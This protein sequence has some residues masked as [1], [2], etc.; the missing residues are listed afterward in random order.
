MKQQQQQQQH[1]RNREKKIWKILRIHTLSS[2]L[3]FFSLPIG[4]K[5][6]ASATLTGGRG[7]GGWAGRGFSA[8]VPNLPL[9]ALW[10]NKRRMSHDFNDI[11]P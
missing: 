5:Y 11:H 6:P 4:N 2:S 9:Y 8:D 1:S 3:F 7:G 10:M